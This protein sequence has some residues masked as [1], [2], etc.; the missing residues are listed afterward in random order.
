MR[1]FVQNPAPSVKDYADAVI[2]T[3]VQSGR[4]PTKWRDPVTR[5]PRMELHDT[6]ARAFSAHLAT[7]PE[8]TYTTNLRRDRKDLD[9]V[10]DFLYHTKAGHCER[11]ASALALMLRSQGIPTVLVLGFKGCEP[12]DEPGKYI[13]RHEHAHAWVDALVPLPNQPQPQTLREVQYHWLSL[14]PTP[15]GSSQT[16]TATHQTLVSGAWS[17]L[18]SLFHDYISN[19]TAEKRRRAIAAFGAW[20]TQWEVIAGAVLVIVGFVLLR[21]QLRR[22]RATRPAAPTDRDSRW[23][24]RLL[25]VLAAHGFVPASRDTPREFASGV[26]DA[27]RRNPTTAP[28]AEVPLDWAEAYYETRF[29]GNPLPPDRRAT[30]ETQL[31]DLR[32]A[33]GKGR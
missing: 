17:E 23:F 28:L 24:D 4:L 15:T 12:G 31:D 1:P 27:L 9:P 3:L 33:L 16:Q 21:R 14:D 5:L 13:V 26:A 20:V 6:V 30:L 29:G 8:L 7:T 25:A 2:D 22:W 11:F 19:Y 18:R 32:N 10:E